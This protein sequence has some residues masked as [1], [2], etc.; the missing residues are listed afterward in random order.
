MPVIFI[1]TLKLLLQLTGLLQIHVEGLSMN[2]RNY[3]N[4]PS[5]WIYL[6]PEQ[7][8][9][10]SVHLIHETANPTGRFLHFEAV[11]CRLTCN[12]YC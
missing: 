4:D 3:I 8:P 7:T 11:T 2:Q 5:G 1:I 10:I 12:S 9:N 6:R